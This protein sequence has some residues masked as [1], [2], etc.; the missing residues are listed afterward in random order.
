MQ[1]FTLAAKN[2]YGGY[3]GNRWYLAVLH[4]DR[5]IHVFADDGRYHDKEVERF[6]PSAGAPNAAAP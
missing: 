4:N 3:T 5:V 6:C 2:A 1:P